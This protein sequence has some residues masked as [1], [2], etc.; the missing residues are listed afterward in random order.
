MSEVR[1]MEESDEKKRDA[2]SRAG[3]LPYVCDPKLG[4]GSGQTGA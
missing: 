3:F 2:K 4:L 1:S